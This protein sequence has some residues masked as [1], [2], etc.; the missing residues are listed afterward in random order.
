[1][2]GCMM[3]SLEHG[4]YLC[5]AQVLK[6]LRFEP[7]YFWTALLHMRCRNGLSQAGTLRVGQGF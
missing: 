7:V 3:C 6:W 5:V 1:M 2:R 4:R